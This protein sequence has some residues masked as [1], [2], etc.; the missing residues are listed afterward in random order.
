[1]N[2]QLYY[3]LF[4]DKFWFTYHSNELMRTAQS[5]HFMHTKQVTTFAITNVAI[6][7]S[8]CLCFAA[9]VC[10]FSK[11]AEMHGHYNTT[12][13]RNIWKDTGKTTMLKSPKTVLS[14]MNAAVPMGFLQLLLS[15]K[16]LFFSTTV[17]QSSWWMLAGPKAISRQVRNDS[18]F[19]LLYSILYTGDHL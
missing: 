15:I 12:G 17:S 4:V 8:P 2:S 9:C 7:R 16:M 11:K 6:F 3:V 13:C 5:S 14:G 10:T 19:C 18:P 1:M